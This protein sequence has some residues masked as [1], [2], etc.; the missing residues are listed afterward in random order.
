MKKNIG[1]ILI[2]FCLYSC[3]W[4]QEHDF[5]LVQVSNH[6]S[7]PVMV[8]TGLT[9]I[10]VEVPPQGAVGVS[11]VIGEEVCAKGKIS[12]LSYGC[13]TFYKYSNATWDIY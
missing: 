8:E 10:E 3:N 7:E 13:Q 4:G 1:F 11:V 5:V 12:N 2:M 6:V 9:F